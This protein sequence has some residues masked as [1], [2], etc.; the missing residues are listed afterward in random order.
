MPRAP[1]P[2]DLYHLRVPVELRLSPDGRLA[3]YTVKTVAPGRD[4]YRFALWIVATDGSAPARQLTLGATCD[5]APRWSPD[6]RT[7]AFLSDRA[8][9][10]QAAGAADRPGLAK[11]WPKE[12]CRQVWL[13]PLDGGEAR[14]LTRLPYDVSDLTWSPD[15]R[16]LC[17]VSASLSTTAARSQ[18]D[19]ADPP[20]PDARSIDRLGYMLNDVGFIYDRPGKLWRVEVESGEAVRLTSGPIP[21]RSPAWS[22]DGRSIAFV[23]ERHRDRDLIWRSD[24]YLVPAAGGR[25]VRVTGGRGERLFDDPTWSPDG[26]WLA[27][28]GH[29]FPAHNASRVD[30]WR[31]RPQ[32]E[33]EGEDLTAASDLMI[34]AGMNSDLDHGAGSPIRWSADQ[35]WITFTAPIEGAYEAW[36]VEVETRTV[37]RLTEGRHWLQAMDQ[38]ALAG[39]RAR[40]AA[41]RVTASAPLDVVTADLPAGPLRGKRVDLRRVADT[42]PP[43]WADIAL[44][45]PEVRWHEVDGRRIQGWFYPAPSRPDGGPA[46]LVVEIHGGPATLYG[47]S[48]M[49]EWQ[50]LVAARMSVYACNPRGSMGYGEAF[51]HANFGDW[52]SGPMADVMGGVDALIA[53]GLADPERLGVTGGSYG[54]YLTSWIVGHTQRFKAAVTCRSVNDMTSQM[55]SGDIGGPSFGRYEFGAN[56][57]E[58]PQLYLRESPLT[59]AK[60]IRTPLLI[61]HSERDLRCTITQAEELF[62]TLRS[63]RRPVRLYRVPGE[64][65]ELT[66]SGTPFRR[67]ANLEVIR[68]WFRHF[69]VEEKRGLPPA[70]RH[71][72]AIVAAR[73]RQSGRAA[74][75]RPALLAQRPA[76]HSRSGP[77]AAVS[78]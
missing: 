32:A 64:S 17:V 75:P 28:K 5:N 67:V 27:V 2:D 25:P 45:E 71:A 76:S 59:Y 10:L 30:L 50:C 11:E 70:P 26:A 61:Q 12:G 23:S 52:G 35:R 74:Q 78:A 8:G 31:F 49:W 21:D 68:D 58:D 42:R 37:E 3:A 57:W 36:R 53:D 4:G 16:Q 48:L 6:G 19:P 62:A 56:P 60:E 7:L 51:G 44:V 15:G 46:P 18:R 65:H 47:Y 39:G 66:R 38:V 13:L 77:R 69:L 73:G 41:L 63:L 40:L 14:Q 43:E 72:G 55:M 1:R 22:P 29:R 20:E 33:Q 34:D 54:G 24:V 9:M